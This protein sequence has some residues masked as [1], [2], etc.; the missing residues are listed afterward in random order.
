M[1]AALTVLVVDDVADQRELLRT[2]LEQAGCV[3]RTCAD[4][5]AVGRVLAGERVDAAVLDLLMPD[6]DGWDV[7]ARIRERSPATIVVF[8]SVLDAA[9]HPADAPSLPK[10][11]TGRQVRELVAR[12]RGLRAEQGGVA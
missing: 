2:H 3:V 7:A 8:A 1:S 10:P 6:A 4:L 5:D 11:Y 12:L 9:D